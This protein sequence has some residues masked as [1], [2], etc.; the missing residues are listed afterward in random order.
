MAKVKFFAVDLKSTYNALT[1]KDEFALYWIMETQEL[2]KGDVLFGVGAEATANMAG[3]MSAEDKQ[4]LDTLAGITGA[5]HFLGVSSTNPADGVV[6]IDGE[7]VIP[8][9]G[10]IVIYESKEFICDKN[11]NL[12]ELGDESIYLTAATAE[13]DYL[14]KLDAENIYQSKADAEA[15]HKALE[16]AINLIDVKDIAWGKDNANGTKFEVIKAVDGFLTNEAQNDLRVYIPKGSKYE[17]QQVGAGGN[18]NTYYMTV[19]A[20]APTANVTA[21]R[22]GDYKNYNEHFAG[23]EKISVDKESGRPYVDFWLGIASTSDGGVT[24]TE[25][26][27]QSTGTKYIGWDWLV[28]WYNGE[29]LVASGSKK[30]T[31]VNNRDMFYNSKDWY[32]PALEAKLAETTTQLEETVGKLE[33]ASSALTW[34]KI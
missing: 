13:A 26:A 33:E 9:A 5:M 24:W 23:M 7:V 3:L 8:K 31:L 21:C 1:I 14:K 29:E 12:V 27:D 6:T 22:K 19:R 16:E 15:E 20:W 32:I 30:I 28:E 11:G 10:D 18:S 34:G 17:V 25:F 4:K 2:Y